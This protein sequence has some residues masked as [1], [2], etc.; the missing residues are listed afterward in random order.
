MENCSLYFDFP[1][2]P[3]TATN[4]THISSSEGEA[5]TLYV[6]AL[7]GNKRLNPRLTTWATKPARRNYLGSARVTYGTKVLLSTFQCK[8]GSYQTF[9]IGCSSKDCNVT[10]TD[11]EW[12]KDGKYYTSYGIL[13]LNDNPFSPSI[14]YNSKPNTLNMP[15]LK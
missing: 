2:T 7:E 1:A 10:S 14:L 5:A 9:E 6:W 4:I 8:S 12:K 11:F 15:I 13:A 3:S